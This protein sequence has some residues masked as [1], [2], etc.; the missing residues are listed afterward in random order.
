MGTP[1]VLAA[2]H[3]D[4]VSIEQLIRAGVHIDARVA[5]GI[6]ALHMVGGV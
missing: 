3:R 5:D 4:S 1:L 6:A 2:W